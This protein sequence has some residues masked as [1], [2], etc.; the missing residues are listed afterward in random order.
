MLIER[1]KKAETLSNMWMGNNLAYEGL[2]EVIKDLGIKP[3]KKAEP[4]IAEVNRDW[5][6]LAT[7]MAGRK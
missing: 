2:K 6:R 7:F 4:S 5:N 3:Q 1:E